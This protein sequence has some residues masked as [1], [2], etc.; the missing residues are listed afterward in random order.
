MPSRGG[1]PRDRAMMAWNS[2]VANQALSYR[3]MPYI[4]G[5]ASPSR[6]F[7]CSGL[8][9]FLLRQRGLNP[10]R[11][12]AGYRTYGKAVARGHWQTGDLILFANTYKRGISHIGV[13]LKDGKFVHAA[14]TGKG[15]RVDSLSKGYFASK[16]WGA[17]RVK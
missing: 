15:V 7:D 16:Y 13:Y 5:A 14:S 3:G 12:A 1:S 10:P 11:T 2:G 9:Y 8:V 6:G 17:R 4:F